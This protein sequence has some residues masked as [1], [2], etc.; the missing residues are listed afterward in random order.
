M[1]LMYEKDKIFNNYEKSSQFVDLVLDY[2][3]KFKSNIILITSEVEDFL[4][5]E[6][7]W[8][9]QDLHARLFRVLILS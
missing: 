4:K 8:T 2:Y 3:R 9:G 1:E 5:K 7:R 6:R